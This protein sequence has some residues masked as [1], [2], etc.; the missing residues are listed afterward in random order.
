MAE[1]YI[2]D[3]SVTKTKLLIVQW[4]KVDDSKSLMVIQIICSIIYKRVTRINSDLAPQKNLTNHNHA[5]LVHSLLPACKSLKSKIWI[6]YPFVS[7]TFSYQLES[8]HQIPFSNQCKHI[9]ITITQLQYHIYDQSNLTILVNMLSTWHLISLEMLSLPPKCESNLNIET[10][11]VH[12]VDKKD[13][14][15]GLHADKVECREFTRKMIH[16]K[17]PKASKIASK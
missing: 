14:T 12:F 11:W 16:H 5:Y 10:L 7:K 17:Y 2:L 9:L 13:G 8:S 15:F 1:T 4:S 3:N 6:V